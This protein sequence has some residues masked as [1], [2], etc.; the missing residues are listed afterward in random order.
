MYKEFY[1]ITL[2]EINHLENLGID[3]RIVKWLLKK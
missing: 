2:K 1:L 3:E